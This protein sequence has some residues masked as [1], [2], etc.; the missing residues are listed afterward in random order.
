M[1]LTKLILV[2]RKAFEA[3]LMVSAVVGSVMTIA[4][5]EDPNSS[6]TAV[7]ARASVEPT[8]IRSGWRL[9]LT[10]VPSRRNSGLDTT[11]MSDRPMVRSTRFTVPTGTVDL[12]MTMAPCSRNGPISAAAATT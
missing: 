1:A 11:A 7:A 8:T 2:A 4:A 6:A 12:L 9:S 10:A 5:P 3:Y